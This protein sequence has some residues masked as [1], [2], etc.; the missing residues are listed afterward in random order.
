[1]FL[2]FNLSQ[3]DAVLDTMRNEKPLYAFYS[4]QDNAGLRSGVE[5]TG[6]EET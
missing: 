6:E 3:L 4:A 5:P 1:V 2:H